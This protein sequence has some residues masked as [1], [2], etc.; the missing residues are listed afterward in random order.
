L[1]TNIQPSASTIK[2]LVLNEIEK[3]SYQTS[4]NNTPK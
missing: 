3:E 1:T 2:T 4:N